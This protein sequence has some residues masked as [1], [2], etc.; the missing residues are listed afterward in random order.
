MAHEQKYQTWPAASLSVTPRLLLAVVCVAADASAQTA[1]PPPPP[2][3][4]PWIL[5]EFFL[6]RNA[7]PQARNEVQVTWTLDRHRDGDVKSTTVGLE[8]EYGITDRLQIEGEVPWQRL[9]RHDEPATTRWGDVEAGL[10]YAFARGP[11][12]MLSAGADLELPTADDEPAREERGAEVAPFVIVGATVGRSEVHASLSY[13]LGGARDLSYHLA[14]VAPFRHWRGTLELNG[15]RQDG[16]T[17]VRLTPGVVWKGL[18]GWEVG[19]AVPVG[20]H[21]APRAG[22]M[23]LVDAEFF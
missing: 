16:A 23:L 1:A 15:Q 11:R 21:G 9:R 13:G 4:P 22:I 7:H 19:V 8:L 2:E 20:L 10:L 5:E 18:R 6:A 12:R 3:P 14:A 17:S